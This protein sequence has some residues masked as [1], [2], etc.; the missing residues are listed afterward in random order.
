MARKTDRKNSR[1]RT[2]ESRQTEQRLS[3]SDYE[4]QSET[5]SIRDRLESI[6]N[7]FDLLD[8]Q[9]DVLESKLKIEPL[10]SEESENPKK[11]R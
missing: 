5:E 4:A 3:V 11:P 7:N 1:K 6:R 10:L 9:L 8:H 2:A